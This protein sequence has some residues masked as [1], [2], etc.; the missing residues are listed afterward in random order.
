MTRKTDIERRAV[1]RTLATASG[2]ALTSA[3]LPRQAAAA[4]DAATTLKA[5]AMNKMKGRATIILVHGAWADGSSWSAVIRPLQS[6]GLPVIAAPLPLTSFMDDVTALNRTLER[7]EGPVVLV[8]HAYAGAVISACASERVKSLVFIAAL[9]PDEGE[10]VGDVFY[11]LPAHPDTA[12]LA[13]DANGLIWMAEG[14]FGKAFAQRAAPA[15]THLL[16]ATQRPIDVVCIKQPVPKPGWKT[17]PSWFLIAE[18]DRMINPQT[19]HFMANRMK[20]H[21]TS[22]Q[23]DHIPLVTSAD[24]VVEI[25]RQSVEALG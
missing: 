1:L 9:A 16:Y 24:D 20:A 8:A 11:R 25:I 7:T 14:D 2:A 13:P 19:Q 15:E 22:R 12:K 18:E 21:I 10:T 6:M 5:A 17:R 23:V 4:S 3:V